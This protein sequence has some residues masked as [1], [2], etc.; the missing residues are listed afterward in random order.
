[1]RFASFFRTWSSALSILVLLAAGLVSSIEVYLVETEHELLQ[2]LVVGT[3][4]S[5]VRRL[6]RGFRV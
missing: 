1:V 6:V 3:F 4:D 5:E 2:D